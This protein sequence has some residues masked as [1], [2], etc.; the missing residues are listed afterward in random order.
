[1]SEHNITVQGGSSVRLP[2]AGKYCD[3][4]IV[5]TAEGGGADLP[6]LTSPAAAT[7]IVKDK[8][9]IGADGSVIT[10]TVEDPGTRDWYLEQYLGHDFVNS[11]V[12]F[13]GMFDAGNGTVLRGENPMVVQFPASYLGNA[14]AGDVA[15]GKTFTSAAGLNVVGTAQAG[16][17]GTTHTITLNAYDA[18]FSLWWADNAYTGLS[19]N[20]H[21]P[22]IE[23]VGDQMIAVFVRYM[24]AGVVP[25]GCVGWGSGATLMLDGSDYYGFLFFLHVSGSE[26]TG[27]IEIYGY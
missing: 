16:G 23:V 26:P 5:V 6:A 3:R 10:G 2:T 19:T 11:K 24:S 1:M 22:T 17:G 21:P 12:E 20:D 27:S 9:V 7:D 4:D 8:Q 25:S 15:A 13:A 14:A 18:E